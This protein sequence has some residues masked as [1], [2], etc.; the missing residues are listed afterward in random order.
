MG[1]RN[2]IDWESIE[3]DVRAGQLSWEAIAKAHGVSCSQVRAKAKENGWERDLSAAIDARTQ[4][5]LAQIDVEELVEQSAR[6]SAGQSAELI[7][8]AVEQAADA[9]AGVL[10]RHRASIRLQHERATRLETLFDEQLN[11]ATGD[12]N[13]AALVQIFRTL[14]ETR[15]KLNDQ[16][17][18]A[19][20]FD[21]KDEG[22]EQPPAFI[23]IQF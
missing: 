20:G 4:A 22:K 23:S 10:Q 19:F 17:R 16:E 14:V 6:E 11:E 1:R 13:L 5:K 21:K 2:D 7:R 3:K 9:K 8:Q 18:Q 12:K 15:G